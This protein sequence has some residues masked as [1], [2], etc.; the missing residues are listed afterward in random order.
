M[1]NANEVLSE[2]ERL[3]VRAADELLRASGFS[4]ITPGSIQAD[5]GYAAG[6]LVVGEAIKARFV[7]MLPRREGASPADVARREDWARE[8][9][10]QLAGRT[11]TKLRNLGYEYTLTPPVALDAAS[12]KFVQSAPGYY[13]ARNGSGCIV[14]VSVDELG[15]PSPDVEAEG[16]MV[17]GELALF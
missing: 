15:P 2:V 7:V 3:T 14:W 12:T 9:A 6:V 11:K 17:E 13:Y 1:Q 5:V 16:A 4:R 8:A 10:N